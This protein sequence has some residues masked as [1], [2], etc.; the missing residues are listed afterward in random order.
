MGGKALH[1]GVGEEAM[2]PITGWRAL[3]GGATF[4]LK[5]RSCFVEV[6]R[7]LA[8]ELDWQDLAAAAGAPWQAPQICSAPFC[9][10][11]VVAGRRLY[12]EPGP[13]WRPEAAK[14]EGNV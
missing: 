4:A 1:V 14:A 11:Q 13:H 3:G 10:G 6:I 7:V 12:L 9:L 5:S 2:P 8:R